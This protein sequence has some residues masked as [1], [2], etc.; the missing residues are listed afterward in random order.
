MSL[1]QIQMGPKRSWKAMKG[2]W[3]SQAPFQDS[4]H[5]SRWNPASSAFWLQPQNSALF[6][7]GLGNCALI[8][9]LFLQL[10]PMSWCFISALWLHPTDKN[11]LVPTLSLS[12][13]FSPSRGGGRGRLNNLEEGQMCNSALPVLRLIKSQATRSHS[14]WD[15]RGCHRT[16]K[17]RETSHGL[18]TQR[19]SPFLLQ[20]MHRKIIT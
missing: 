14:W 15:I 17:E 8:F 2:Q 5:G 19:V 13:L 9:L 10:F 11:Y 18:L 12:P 6:L 4:I 20:I 1:T 3:A 16:T 7:P